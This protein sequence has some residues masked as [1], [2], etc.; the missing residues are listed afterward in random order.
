VLGTAIL[1][2]LTLA[3]TPAMAQ[4]QWGQY[5]PPVWGQSAPPA[6]AQYNARIGVGGW[7][8]NRTLRFNEAEGALLN[9]NQL[10]PGGSPKPSIFSHPDT[11]LLGRNAPP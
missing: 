3:A 6:W 11:R 2:L 8:Y 5:M 10:G 7:N 1:L 4:A 9:P